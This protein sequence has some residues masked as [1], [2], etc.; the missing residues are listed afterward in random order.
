M[1]KR[2]FLIIAAVII[3][4][5]GFFILPTLLSKLTPSRSNAKIAKPTND[6][7][8]T[9]TAEKVAVFETGQEYL[10]SNGKIEEKVKINPNE[11]D[12]IENKLREIQA[13]EGLNQNLFDV[14]GRA[15][16]GSWLKELDHL[17]INKLEVELRDIEKEV[18]EL[19]IKNAVRLRSYKERQAQ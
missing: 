2:M 14:E 11:I 7:L 9:A 16:I 4:G 1:F 8:D 3:L 12:E 19:E 17:R 18:A 13:I 15:Q 5:F 6:I 10:S